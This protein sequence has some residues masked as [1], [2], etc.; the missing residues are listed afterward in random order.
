MRVSRTG[1]GDSPRAAHTV[2]EAAPNS[3]GL[4][5]L[6]GTGDARR[7]VTPAGDQ[8]LDLRVRRHP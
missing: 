1:L 6:R 7:V 2:I 4:V 8:V 5:V 3:R